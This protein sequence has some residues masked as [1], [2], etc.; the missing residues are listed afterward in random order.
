MLQSDAERAVN[1]LVID[2]SSDRAAVGVMTAS[3][4]VHS[5]GTEAARR[6]GRDLVPCVREL[7]GRAR[8]AMAHLD[9]V[10]V[11]IGPGS[12]T[13]LRIGLMAA[14]TIAYATGAD[15]VGFDSLEG[16]ARNAPPSARRVHV[17]ADAQ[18][19]DV[20]AAVFAREADGMPL[21]PISRSRIQP[22]SAWPG[23]WEAGDLVLGP[24]LDAATVRAAL[25]AGMTIAAAD[26]HR[27]RAES[28]LELARD[29]W[30][31]G[32]RDALWTLEPNYLRRS[33]AEDQWDASGSGRRHS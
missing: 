12:Y 30:A 21:V 2:T 8:Q 14:K 25:P 27:P 3:G 5:A 15:L 29:L 11:G 16:L 22:V 9:V 20:Y 6:H 31:G 19:G 4:C 17:V 28:L 18:R 13:G 1:L 10:A 7:L 26:L 23:S 24:G 33:A 32:R